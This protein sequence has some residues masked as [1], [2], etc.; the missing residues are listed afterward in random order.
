MYERFVQP[1]RDSSIDIDVSPLLLRTGTKFG[2]VTHIFRMQAK[3][4]LEYW[5]SRATQCLQNAV[6]R[7]KELVFRMY[8]KIEILSRGR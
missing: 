2:T 4:D 5:I 3:L 6:I 1:H 8:K 7:A